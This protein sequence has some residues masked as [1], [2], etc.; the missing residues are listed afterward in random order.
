M[1]RLGS[2]TINRDRNSRGDSE[3]VGFGTLESTSQ[4]RLAENQAPSSASISSVARKQTQTYT[5]NPSD[6]P[7]EHPALV[8]CAICTCVTGQQIKQT[9]KPAPAPAPAPSA[10]IF[11]SRS[12]DL[13]A[14]AVA[15]G[16]TENLSGPFRSATQKE[17]RSLRS[18]P[19]TR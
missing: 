9:D 10:S 7:G 19:L 11:K 5:S 18:N 8:K 2:L 15:V 1:S 13:A 4:P 16:T 12:Y 17:T 14:T 6:D 3:V